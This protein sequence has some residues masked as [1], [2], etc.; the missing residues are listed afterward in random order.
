MVKNVAFTLKT[1]IVQ[2][3]YVKGIEKL[4]T[5]WWSYWLSC[6]TFKCKP[7]FSQKL[8]TTF[9]SALFCNIYANAVWI[10]LKSLLFSLK[11]N[12][13]W[14]QSAIAKIAISLAT[15][16]GS[17]K[18]FD[19]SHQFVC[20]LKFWTKIDLMHFTVIEVFSLISF[21]QKLNKFSKITTNL[22]FVHTSK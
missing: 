5:W 1:C 2:F 16:S 14:I 19:F 13:N 4:V 18:L 6:D 7:E 9:Y 17:R 8:Y 22:N 21:T 15:R 12:F 20:L 3:L 11:E 10:R